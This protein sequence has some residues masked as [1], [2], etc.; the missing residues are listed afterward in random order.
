MIMGETE[1]IRRLTESEQWA[2]ALFRLMPGDYPD[3]GTR[4]PGPPPPPSP[5]SNPFVEVGRALEWS[6]ALLWGGIA[7]IAVAVLVYLYLT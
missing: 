1:G 2:L 5:D 6:Q 3:S 7:C 4:K